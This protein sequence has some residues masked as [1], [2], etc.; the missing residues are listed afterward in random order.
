[1]DW[2]Q[3]QKPQRYIGNEWNVVRKP[4]SG[5]IRVCVCYPDLYEVGMSNVGLRIVYGALNQN[6]KVVCERVF[7]PGADLARY[8]KNHNRKLFSLETKT[9]LDEFDVV[10]FHLGYELNYT[11]FLSILDLSGIPL[12]AGE[13]K[14]AGGYPLI[15]AGGVNNPEVIA[16]FCDVIFLGE[17]EV[18][19]DGFIEVIAGSRGRT[20]RLEALSEREGFYVP[21][22]Y[23]VIDTPEGPVWEKN[24]ASAHF[25]LRRQYVRDLNTSFYPL[26]WIVPYTQIVHDRA[27]VEIARGCPHNCY[28][29]QA[30]CVYYP[31]REKNADCVLSQI[32]RIYASSGYE[33]FSLLA[34]SASNH[35]QIGTII[36]GAGKMFKDK[37]VGIA[38]PSLR[39]DD[40]VGTLYPKLQALKKTSLT[41]ALEAGT[42]QMR[43]KINKKIDIGA[44][45]EAKDMLRSLGLRHIKL[46]F[47]FGFPQEADDDLYAIA[48]LIRRVR[49][50]LRI[51]LNVS[52]NVF[53]PKP[54]SR[55]QNVPMEDP[56]ELLRKKKI[57]LR[58]LSRDTS[59]LS[60]SNIEKSILEAVMSR[61]DR[62]LARV[63]LKAFELGARFDSYQES[64]DWTLWEKAFLENN[65]DYRRYL[66]PV[67]EGARAGWSYI[68]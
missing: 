59:H 51:K 56:A 52:V 29:C 36:E 2:V 28:F 47:M 34:L 8:L 63:V 32:E 25:P 11:N 13:R 46:Y 66:V 17:Y 68:T 16:P 54:F 23:D 43:E 44:V 41:L 12:T 5:R 65:I 64:F 1:M 31:Y 42:P 50:R 6:E 55:F 67:G 38:L 26:R 35:S 27:Q 39:V 53:I 48:E 45:L 15:L 4:H 24:Y 61:G 57:I 62:K 9:A 20:E 30:R 10:G 19:V 49:S 7:S 58:S 14:K 60:V 21:E 18:G 3:F 37:G 22:F 40:V 33:N